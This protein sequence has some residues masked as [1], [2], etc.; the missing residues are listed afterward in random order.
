MN[1]LVCFGT[2]PEAIKL[3]PVIHEL[4]KQGVAHTVCV[5]GQHREILDQ[6]LNFFE[7]VPDYDL[8]LMQHDQSLNGLSARI[9]FEIDRILKVENPSIVLVQGDTTTATMIALGA[10]QRGV[11]VAHVEAGLRT[12]NKKA[13][14]PEEVNRQ[15]IA[16]VADFHFAPTSKAKNFLDKESIE[17][18]SIFIT[19]NTAVDALLW[20]KIK[21]DKL[22]KN[23]EI[24]RIERKLCA[25]KKMILV[26]GHR[27]ENFGS[28]LK[29]I[30]KAL[31]QLA[32]REDVEICYPV[33]PNPKVS[34]TV[35]RMLHNSSKIYLL[36]PVSYPTMI[37]L[38][39]RAQIIISDSGGIQEEAPT[40]KKPVI[41]TREVTE[42]PEGVEAGFC[43]L[44]GTKKGM[45]VNEAM[46]LLNN[47][48]NFDGKENPYGD[49]T[50]ARKIVDILRTKF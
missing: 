41:V 34:E 3:A 28:G 21:L 23:D 32:E 20:S 29:E 16:R 22:P 24:L 38:I 2:R 26:T 46:K 14:F 10:F 35:K 31:L 5:T 36:A 48:P 39:N 40:L 37:W 1:I 47:P 43:A 44:T 11:K 4:R 13:P 19:G 17:N 42:R 8:N 50:A 15:L 33:H 27:R 18:D 45:I 7:I 9:I 25:G 30:C 12:Y 49:G 6:V